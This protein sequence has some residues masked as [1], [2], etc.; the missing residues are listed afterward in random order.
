MSVFAMGIICAHIACAI[1][2]VFVF[3]GWLSP[4][5]DDQGY[6]TRID[7]RI[8]DTTG[9]TMSTAEQLQVMAARRQLSNQ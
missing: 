6:V 5:D 8:E 4:L 7:Q 9:L 2:N 1:N 3:S